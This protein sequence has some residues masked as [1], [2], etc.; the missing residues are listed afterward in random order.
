MHLFNKKYANIMT[1]SLVANINNCFET[2]PI[3]IILTAMLQRL[4]Y[5]VF[6]PDCFLLLFILLQS[7]QKELYTVYF[8]L[9]QS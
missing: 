3:S 1:C 5:G 2:L 6:M 8:P 9:K 7:K 4:K